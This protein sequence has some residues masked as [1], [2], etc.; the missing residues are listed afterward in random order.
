MLHRLLKNLHSA[1]SASDKNRGREGYFSP[2]VMQH[3]KHQISF[4][5]INTTL[6]LVWD[7]WGIS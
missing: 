7:D 1:E 5:L 3:K 2:A 4:Y 6:P